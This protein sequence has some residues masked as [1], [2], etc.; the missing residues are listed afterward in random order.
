MK[1]DDLLYIYK[2]VLRPIIE[3]ALPKYGPM[4]SNELSNEIERLQLQAC[5]NI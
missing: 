4:L 5:K 2:T 1:I 3:Y